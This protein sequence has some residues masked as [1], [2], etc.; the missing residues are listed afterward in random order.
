MR[1]VKVNHGFL[2]MTGYLRAALIGRSIHELD[3]LKGAD[4]RDLAVERLHGGMTVPQME[5]RLASRR[6]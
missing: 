3:I 2:E 4:K 5:A 1:Y 6:R